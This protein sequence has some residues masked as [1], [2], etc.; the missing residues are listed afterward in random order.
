MGRS[1][2][3]KLFVT[4]CSGSYEDATLPSEYLRSAEQKMK[5]ILKPM[6]GENITLIYTIEVKNK[7]E[8]EKWLRF[9]TKTRRNDDTDMLDAQ[10]ENCDF[11]EWEVVEE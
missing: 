3:N 10:L 8:G 4:H 11:F 6:Y 7:K 2:T 5:N 1:S 9:L